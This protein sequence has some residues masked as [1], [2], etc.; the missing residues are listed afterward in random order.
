ML[1]EIGTVTLMR[2]GSEKGPWG[3]IGPLVMSIYVCHRNLYLSDVYLCVNLSD[4]S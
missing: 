4:D 1:F 3:Y 2:G